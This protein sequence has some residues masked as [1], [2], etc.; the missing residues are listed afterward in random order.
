[1]M[2]DGLHLTEQGLNEIRNLASQMNRSRFSFEDVSILRSFA[3]S[4][5]DRLN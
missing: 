2:C 1:M 5:K 4:K 3:N